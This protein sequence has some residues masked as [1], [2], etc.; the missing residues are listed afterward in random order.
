MTPKSASLDC[1]PVEILEPIFRLL[2]PIGLISISQTNSYFRKVVQ[3]KREHF[4]ERLLALECTPRYE[5][6]WACSH[7]LRMRPLHAGFPL[8][9][10]MRGLAY[11]K[12]PPGSLAAESYKYTSWEPS[13]DVRHRQCAEETRDFMEEHDIET[14]YYLSSLSADREEGPHDRLEQRLKDFQRSGMVTFQELDLDEYVDLTQKEEQALL[15]YENHLVEQEYSGYKRHLREC[16]RCKRS[17]RREPL[18][19][20][21]AVKHASG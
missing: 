11:S 4:L 14:R 7:C 20:S 21:R 10:W 3:P 9:V 17:R 15:D 19:S 12:P 13:G 6:L 1:L 18:A 5:H 8:E 16:I 2:D